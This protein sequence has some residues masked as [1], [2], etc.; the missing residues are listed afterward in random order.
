MEFIF[1][2][3][4]LPLVPPKHLICA[5]AG[6]LSLTDAFT[7]AH[8][9]HQTGSVVHDQFLDQGIGHFS[10]ATVHHIAQCFQPG[11]VALAV[12]HSRN[13]CH[14]FGVSVP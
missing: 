5:L 7:A 4:F 2:I 9:N 10:I 14:P 13:G 1:Y 8:P 12:L 3:V 6:Y 11:V